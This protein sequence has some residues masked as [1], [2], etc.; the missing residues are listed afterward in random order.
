MFKKKN[1]SKGLLT[2]S[3][4]FSMVLF[5]DGWC[6]GR[7]FDTYLWRCDIRSHAAKINAFLFTGRRVVVLRSMNIVTEAKKGC[8][9][10]LLQPAATPHVVNST[11]KSLLPDGTSAWWGDGR[12]EKR[13]PTQNEFPL[14]FV[15][16]QEN[17]CL[18]PSTSYDAS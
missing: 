16:Q 17:S 15:V 12:K 11:T 1:Y 5:P 10:I 9:N 4:A 14:I 6:A 8:V 3:C 13:F 7:Y 18:S 2:Q